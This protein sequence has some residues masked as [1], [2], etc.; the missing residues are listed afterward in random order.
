MRLAFRFLASTVAGIGNQDAKGTTPMTRPSYQQL[1][2]RMA[3]AADTAAGPEALAALTD[4]FAALGQQALAE[5][6][7]HG[8]HWGI[9]AD[10]CWRNDTPALPADGGSCQ[11]FLHDMAA[12]IEDAD[13]LLEI[14]A[15]ITG[16]HID[17]GYP[18]PWP[19]S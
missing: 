7:S 10:W 18:D 13:E 1:R 9:W 14:C 19:T 17:S 8:T 3:N 16:G 12:E 11:R 6:R 5:R 4:A 2:E 15:A